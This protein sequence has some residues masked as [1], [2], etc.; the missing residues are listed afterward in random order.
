MDSVLLTGKATL[1]VN[2]HGASSDESR[3]GH[4]T[5]MVNGAVIVESIMHTNG[6]SN[7]SGKLGMNALEISKE[8]MGKIPKEP[9][10]SGTLP[11]DASK[12]TSDVVMENNKLPGDTRSSLEVGKVGTT[13][14]GD[15]V[16]NP[17][18][19]PE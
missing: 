4:V 6:T 17:N 7:E 1:I 12:T 16:E 10:D 15:S 13:S 5:T 18:G 14:S 8:K 11:L 9:T 19:A 3:V 2:V